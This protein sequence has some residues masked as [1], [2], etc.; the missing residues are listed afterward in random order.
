MK[1]T[2]LVLFLFTFLQLS[3][4]SPVFAISTPSFPSCANPQG[5]VRASYSE[6]VHG[7]VGS[8]A[9][10][11]GSDAVYTLSDDT[12]TQC[13]CSVNGAGIQTNWWKASALSEEQLKILESLGWIY[14]PNG[15]LWGLAEDPYITKNSNFNC[16]P[17]ASSTPTIH[18]T[19]SED[20]GTGGGDVLGET[21]GSVLGLAATGDSLLVYSSFLLGIVFLYIGISRIKTRI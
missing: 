18:N 14:V 15:N 12:V 3:V 19:V 4:V 2:I 9:T 7:I 5:V 16:L 10:Y 11:T 8:S 21:T 6:G 17:G 20:N 13:F 1:K